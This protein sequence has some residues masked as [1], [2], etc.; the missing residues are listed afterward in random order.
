MGFP[1][2]SWSPTIFGVADLNVL[3]HVVA[4]ND[5]AAKLALESGVDVELPFGNAYK[6]PD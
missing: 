6:H 2:E 4:S 5:E 1:P 3:H